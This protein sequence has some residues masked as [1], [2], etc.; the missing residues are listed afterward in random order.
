M[1]NSRHVRLGL[2]LRTL[3]G[4]VK[5]SASNQRLLLKFGRMR[6][7][8]LMISSK[9]YSQ[10]LRS[11]I[12]PTTPQTTILQSRLWRGPVGRPHYILNCRVR[13]GFRT[14]PSA[15]MSNQCE[16]P[17]VHDCTGLAAFGYQQQAFRSGVY[18]HNSICT[19]FCNVSIFFPRFPMWTGAA[20]VAGL[21]QD[22]G[23]LELNAGG[24]RR[25]NLRHLGSWV[26]GWNPT[27]KPL[28][29]FPQSCITFRSSP[30]IARV[31][32]LKLKKACRS[33]RGARDEG[34]GIPSRA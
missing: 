9:R 25:F 26:S 29:G 10:D 1:N 22:P 28:S 13:F 7:T 12:A 4:I 27:D 34:G 14:C 2:G 3:P 20:F 23:T 30:A 18:C 21:V 15:L 31:A 8:G 24:C 16:K 11:L 33:D 32:M 5:H 17:K 19:G 6:C